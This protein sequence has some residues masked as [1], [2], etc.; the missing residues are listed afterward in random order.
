MTFDA[1]KVPGGDVAQWGDECR[2]RALAALAQADWRGV[3]EWTK[4]WVG[5]G[6]GAWLPD[7]WLLYAT[8]ALL[9][10]EPKNAIHSLDLGLRTWIEGPID[11]AVLTWCRGILVWRLLKD[12]KTALVDLEAAADQVPDWLEDDVASGIQ[13]CQQNA[14]ASRKRVPSAK[15]RPDFSVPSTGRGFAAPPVGSHVDGTRPAVWDQVAANFAN[16]S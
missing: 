11:R 16:P 14:A 13:T 3:Y 9:K 6:G 1:S 12:P 5:W 2:E 7:S 10:N 4:S 15:P 8:S